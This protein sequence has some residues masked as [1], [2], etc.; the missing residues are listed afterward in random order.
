MFLKFRGNQLSLKFQIISEAVSAMLSFLS[1]HP[2][3]IFAHAYDIQ[4]ENQIQNIL[5]AIHMSVGVSFAACSVMLMA[6]EFTVG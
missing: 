2:E 1:G 6:E 4:G 5:F 3:N